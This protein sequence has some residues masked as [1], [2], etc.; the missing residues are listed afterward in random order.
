MITKSVCLLDTQ[1]NFDEMD[2]E[3]SV[4]IPDYP[5]VN[6]MILIKARLL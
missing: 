4:N 6:D 5:L 3:S 1:P 2:D